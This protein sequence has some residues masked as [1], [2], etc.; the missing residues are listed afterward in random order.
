MT[1]FEELREISEDD[2]EYRLLIEV[3]EEFEEQ[4]KGSIKTKSGKA[5]QIVI[6]KFLLIKGI[7]LP[8]NLEV[9][10]EEVKT[11]M[12]LLYL[13]KPGIETDKSQY[14]V[15]DLVVVVKI[16]N[17]AVGKNYAERIRN[18]FAKFAQINQN[19]R[20]A[21]VVLSENLLPP[22]PYIYA[23]KQ[24]D[25]GNLVG[26]FTLVIR[27]TSAFELYLRETVVKLNKNGE[28]RKPKETG[29]KDLLA[30]LEEHLP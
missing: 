24:D 14:S 23:M 30:F 18:T 9:K 3:A 19:L 12:N 25:F 15:N 8:C 20:F 7:R 16:I 10:I 29:L 6:H 11:R 2:D 4:K 13:L 22:T 5:T 1:N 26:V 28:L 21:V 27:K 17:N